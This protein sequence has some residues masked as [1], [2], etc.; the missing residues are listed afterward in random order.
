MENYYEKAGMSE[1]VVEAIS[2][3]EV[4]FPISRF[5]LKTMI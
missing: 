3:Q 2:L 1:K 4:S 5:M